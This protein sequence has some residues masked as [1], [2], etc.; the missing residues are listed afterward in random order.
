MKRI[1][2]ERYNREAHNTPNGWSYS[3]LISGET[4]DGRRWIMWLDED[5]AP[6]VYWPERESDGAVVGEPITLTEQE[7]AR[8]QD[9]LGQI[10]GTND[11]P[12]TYSEWKAQPR[13]GLG[14]TG[15]HIQPIED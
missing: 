13:T 14:G 2:I 5:G 3:G 15:W 11:H 1:T 9:A 7:Y 4:N 8:R 10:Y 12:M 6:A